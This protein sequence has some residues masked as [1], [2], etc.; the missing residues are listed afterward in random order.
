MPTSTSPTTSEKSVPAI[1]MSWPAAPFRG[2]TSV[3]VG[4]ASL[5]YV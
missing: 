4:V 3:I 2:K 5:A 1:E